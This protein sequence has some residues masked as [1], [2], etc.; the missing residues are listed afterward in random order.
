MP[1]L[2]IALVKLLDELIIGDRIGGQNYLFVIV[3]HRDSTMQAK[4]THIQNSTGN[5]AK[6]T[7]ASPRPNYITMVVNKGEKCSSVKLRTNNKNVILNNFSVVSL[8]AKG[9]Q[10]LISF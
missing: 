7:I 5:I 3:H 4:P 8:D 2:H 9:H 1:Y 10:V 6:H